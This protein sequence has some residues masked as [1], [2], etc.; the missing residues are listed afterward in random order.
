M[1]YEEIVRK[2]NNII[3]RNADYKGDLKGK[4]FTDDLKLD[5]VG[6]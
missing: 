6:D 4:S 1:S 3:Y 5:S 2:L